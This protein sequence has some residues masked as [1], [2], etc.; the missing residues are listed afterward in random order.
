MDPRARRCENPYG[1]AAVCFE[2]D[3]SREGD[4]PN[5]SR[6]QGVCGI[7]QGVSFPLPVEPGVY[8]VSQDALYFSVGH[9]DVEKAVARRLGS[10]V[11]GQVNGEVKR[12]IWCERVFGDGLYDNGLKT[13]LF[14]RGRTPGK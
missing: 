12:L 5:F 2:R 9:D 8:V 13:S 7:D 11:K 10:A 14:E 3:C 6:D 1:F 4:A